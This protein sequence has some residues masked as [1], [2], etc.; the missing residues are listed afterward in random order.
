MS[1]TKNSI[2]KSVQKVVGLTRYQSVKTIEGTL[3]IIKET[4]ESGE[5]VL[6]SGF[7]KFSIKENSKPRGGNHSNNN[8]YIP[9]AK[10]V[11]TFR[12]SPV[13]IKKINGN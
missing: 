2:F 6:I 8:A 5:D 4:L 10:K 13:L 1:L 9:E 12:C 11:V 7:G 3:E